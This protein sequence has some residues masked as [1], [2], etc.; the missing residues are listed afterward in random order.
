MHRHTNPR[1]PVRFLQIRQVGM[2]LISFISLSLF[3]RHIYRYDFISINGSPHTAMVFDFM[4]LLFNELNTITKY[5]LMILSMDIKRIIR[6]DDLDELSRYISQYT[7]YPGFNILHE[8]ISRDKLEMSRMIIEKCPQMTSGQDYPS[9]MTPLMYAIIAGDMEFIQLFDGCAEAFSTRNYM[10][11]PPLFIG[12]AH[13]DFR[14]IRY[15]L[16][17]DPSAIYSVNELGHTPLHIASMC[18]CSSDI[19]RFLYNLNRESNGPDALGSFPLHLYG[20]ISDSLRFIDAGAFSSPRAAN[21]ETGGLA[22]LASIDP[23]VLHLRNNKG[24]LPIHEFSVLFSVENSQL[25]KE[26]CAVVTMCPESL[27]VRNN[28]GELPIHISAFYHDVSL[29]TM[30]LVIF[31]H[32]L[33][34]T[35]K[36]RNVL[37][38]FESSSDETKLRIIVSTRR[39]NIELREEFWKF[40]PRPLPGLEKHMLDFPPTVWNRVFAHL[41]RKKRGVIQERYYLVE[42]FMRSKKIILPQEIVNKI[43]LQS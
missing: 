31:P 33:Y 23:D 22:W 1:I 14:G 3:I 12:I 5:L 11:D 25:F 21:E 19:M 41:T 8:T 34:E 38:F 36:A 10:G 15:I 13:L 43:C 20:N 9:G 30:N 37:S 32:L 4:E 26:I 29:V 40:I 6:D 7:Y 35:H 17:Q 28:I 42:K 18:G 27:L 39:A 24:N 16:D 2:L